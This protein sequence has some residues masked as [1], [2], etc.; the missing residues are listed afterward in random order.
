MA[1]PLQI[2][3]HCPCVVAEA[4]RWC[5]AE[6]TLYWVDVAAGRC[7]RSRAGADVEAYACVDPGLGKIGAAIPLGDGKVRLFTERCE[8]WDMTFG[9]APEFR[10]RLAGHEDRRFNDVMTDGGR[11]F[12]GVASAPGLPGELWRL[13]PDGSFDVVE[14]ALAGMPNGMGVSPDGKTFY[15]AVTDERRIYA[16]DYSRATGALSNCRVWADDF[17]EP[18]FPDGLCVDPADGSVYVAMWDG[19]RIERRDASGRLVGTLPFPMK[20]VTS[21]ESVGERLFVTTGNKE[22][23]AA[24][25]FGE[26]GAGAVFVVNKDAL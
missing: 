25:A 22:P 24:A 23:D 16:Y 12:C 7:L 1:C 5:E 17:A 21:V 14:P 3:A 13:L 2:F 6:R 19:A 26:T 8:V 9:R 18:G 20:K 4:P 15:F 11:Y 10:W